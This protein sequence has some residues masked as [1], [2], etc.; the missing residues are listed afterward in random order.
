[1]VIVDG[2]IPSENDSES[3]YLTPVAAP[4]SG[5]GWYTLTRANGAERPAEISLDEARLSQQDS[6]VGTLLEAY[7]WIKERGLAVAAE[8]IQVILIS[9]IGP[10]TGCKARLRIFYSDLLAAA[11]EAVS[12]VPI[13]V[14]SVYNTPE[15]SRD[16]TR[17]N[18]I[19]TT[20][21]YPDA[22]QTPYNISGRQGAYWV[23]R[24][25]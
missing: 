23:Y 10:C 18:M 3:C 25:Q 12:T 21:G 13:T 20:Y 15:A 7:G 14:E 16:R 17:G 2:N 5:Q 11:E 19:P 22:V 8:S 9:N 4:G 6:E 1:M 24:L